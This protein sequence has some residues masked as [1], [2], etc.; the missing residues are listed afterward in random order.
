MKTIPVDCLTPDSV[1]TVDVL[2][3]HGATRKTFNSYVEAKFDSLYPDEI[4]C[5]VDAQGNSTS[6][7]FYYSLPA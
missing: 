2:F 4:C 1:V 3:P 5:H 6:E 7:E